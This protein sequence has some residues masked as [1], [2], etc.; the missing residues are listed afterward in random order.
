M[1][2]GHWPFYLKIDGQLLDGAMI[3]RL[4]IRQEL[5]QHYWCDLEFRLLEQQRPPVASYLGKAI[6]FITFEEFS[7]ELP[8]FSGLVIE[9]ELS[10]ELHG[11]FSAKLSAVTTSYK[12]QLTPEEDYFLKKTLKEVAEKITGE[13]GVELEF[14][15][16]GASARMNYVQWGESDFD[17]LRR[18]ADDQG[19]FL[20]P[21][22]KGIEIR[23][24]FQDVGLKMKWHDEYG[25]VKFS[26]KG[27]LGQPSFTGVCYDPRTMQSQ[28][29]R[30]IKKDPQFF[31]ETATEMIDAVKKQ[32]QQ[33]PSA[34]LVFDGRAPKIDQ[35]KALL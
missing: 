29:F 23:R 8:I 9:A 18:I 12:L 5:G 21:T 3:S 31:P 6:E 27:K 17:F 14:A 13:D 25:L 22:P 20:R 35:Y 24:G 11:D 28:T 7:T 19:C 33:L 34:R 1:A 16:D 2:S 32:S 26:L 4:E 10:Y 15:A 30:K